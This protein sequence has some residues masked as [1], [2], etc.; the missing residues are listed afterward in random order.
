MV[1]QDAQ[2]AEKL[3]QQSEGE[4]VTVAADGAAAALL[5]AARQA[6]LLVDEDGARAIAGLRRA[7]EDGVIQ[8]S[9]TALALVGGRRREAAAPAKRT[10]DGNALAR[11][12]RA[13][14]RP[15]QAG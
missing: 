1:T 12:E 9:Q 2:R 7:V 13:M 8:P 6:A 14:T 10:R 11:V 15:G 5:Q 3:V 4:T